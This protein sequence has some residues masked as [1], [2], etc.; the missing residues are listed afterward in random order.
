MDD[1]LQMT[2]SGL[3]CNVADLYIDPWRPVNRAV[4]THAHADHARAGSQ[5][6]LCTHESEP[7]L[8]T[9][10]GSENNIQSVAY[11]ETL[12]MT[13]VTLSLHP[14]GHIIGSAQVKLVHK[15]RTYVI[16]GD[17][18]TESDPTCAPLEVLRCDVFVSECT[19]GLPIYKWPKPENIFAEINSWW[20][21]N[22]DQ[23]KTSILFAYAL[24]KAQRILAALD[25]SIGTI[26]THG[27]IEKVS[28]CY[29]QMGIPLPETVY[30]GDVEDKRLFTG[31]LVLAP[32]SADNPSW[33]RRFK[34][35][36][37]AFASGWMRIRGNRR[38]RSL[39]RGFILS[40]HSDWN[41]LVATIEATGADH[42]GLTHGYSAE[43]ARWL[44]ETG[45]WAEVIPTEY[46]DPEQ[47]EGENA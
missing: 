42:I 3:Y 6:Y 40:D 17:Y 7:L 15:G 33:M 27:A 47:S 35:R 26:F 28:H 29:R 44:R 39:D 41:G 38:R 37:R 10:L 21:E 13:Y 16:S 9:R 20:R 24:G 30:V 45:H 12:D 5:S 34:S 32:P 46:G 8:R 1:F 4:I 2:P 14:A 23:G 31:A 22:R 19:F 18:K 25:D 43:M 11:G 36:S